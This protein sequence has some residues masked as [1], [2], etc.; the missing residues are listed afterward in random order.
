MDPKYNDI[1][2]LPHHRSETRGHMSA[3]DR[4]A[5]FSPFAA[6]TGFDAAVVETARLTAERIELTEQRMEILNA[7]L[8][9]LL[10]D[11]EAKAE[12]TYFLPD[13]QKSGGEYVRTVGSVRSFDFIEGRILLSDGKV[14]PV[15][16]LYDVEMFSENT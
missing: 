15:N 13:K 1:I 12:F 2:D 7:R 4:A 16:D 10:D 3:S 5:Q 9:M 6:L 8:Q 14:I 11:P